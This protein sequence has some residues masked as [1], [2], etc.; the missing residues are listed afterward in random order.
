MSSAPS[1]VYH[2]H[3]VPMPNLYAFCESRHASGASKWH[4]RPLS[5][6][7]LMLGGGVD[8]DSL[9]G[10]VTPKKG[11]WDLGC[12]IQA[13]TLGIACPKCSA[14]YIAIIQPKDQ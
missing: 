4:I 14:T 8:T 3:E 10:H 13:H 6:K 7:G 12:E 5:D 9:C 1:G 2:L 11:G